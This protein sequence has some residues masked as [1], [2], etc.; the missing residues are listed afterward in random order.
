MFSK[1][2]LCSLPL[3]VIMYCPLKVLS[4]LLDEGV[5]T[6]ASGIFLAH[7]FNKLICEIAEDAPN[8]LLSG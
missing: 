1:R 7:I 3:I 8:F 5:Q 2:L 6:S 4:G